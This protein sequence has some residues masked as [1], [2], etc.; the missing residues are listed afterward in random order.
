MRSSTISN[1]PILRKLGLTED[2]IRDS[3]KLFK[4]I[5]PPPPSSSPR[6][7]KAERFLGYQMLRL[8]REKAMRV[9]G[10]SE[11]DIDIENSK[12]LGS[13]GQTGRRR[14]FVLEYAPSKRGSFCSTSKLSRRGYI[15]RSRSSTKNKHKHF[16]RRRSTGDLVWMKDANNSYS[17]RAVSKKKGEA[18]EEIKLLKQRLQLLEKEIKQNRR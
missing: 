9:L 6:C 11:E 8:K 1:N 4:Q 15:K 10:I 12:N 17:F 14:S 2:D 18:N 16:L 5:P 7:S 3:E 13:L